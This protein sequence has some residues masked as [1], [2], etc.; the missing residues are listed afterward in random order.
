M[1]DQL[2]AVHRPGPPPVVALYPALGSS[3]EDGHS[4][5]YLAVPQ[6]EPDVSHFPDQ[7]LLR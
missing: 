6:W 7:A 1:P 2:G 5:L 3:P 4:G